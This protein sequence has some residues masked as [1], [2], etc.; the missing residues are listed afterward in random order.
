MR[1]ALREYHEMLWVLNE[2]EGWRSGRW[3]VAA[4]GLVA[5]VWAVPLTGAIASADVARAGDG[6]GSVALSAT[7]TLALGGLGAYWSR[8]SPGVD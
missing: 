5:G 3:P 7:V 4:L 1:Y 8:T 2:H 6:F